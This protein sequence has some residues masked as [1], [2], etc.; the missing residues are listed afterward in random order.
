MG[1]CVAAAEFLEIF[2]E[3]LTEFFAVA[4]YLGFISK[5][6]GHPSNCTFD[7]GG[8]I[9]SGEFEVDPASLLAAIDQARVVEDVEVFGDGRWGEIE[10][11]YELAKA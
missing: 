9:S 6:V 7:G 5:R 3:D 2:F 11:V 4:A 8:G 10:E 1:S